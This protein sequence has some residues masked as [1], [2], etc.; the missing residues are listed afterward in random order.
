MELSTGTKIGLKRARSIAELYI[1]LYSLKTIALEVD[2][3]VVIVFSQRKSQNTRPKHVMSSTATTDKGSELRSF[4]AGVGSGLTKMAVGHPFDTVKTRLQCSPPGVFS[5][6][7][8]CLRKTLAKE[9]ILALYKGGLAPAISWGC[10]DAL[11][12]G[13]LHN[14]RLLLLENRLA[15]FTERQPDTDTDSPDKRRLTYAGAYLYLWRLALAFATACHRCSRSRSHSHS[16]SQAKHSRV[17]AQ[18]GQTA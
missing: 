18:D 14:Y 15:F 1:S 2:G 17:W 11:L 9:K 7:I 8:D 6:P 3:D 5:G 4:M 12:M 10:S 13:S 16:H